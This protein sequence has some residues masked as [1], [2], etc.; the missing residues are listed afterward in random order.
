MHFFLDAVASQ[1]AFLGPISILVSL[2]FLDS[3]APSRILTPCLL[4]EHYWIY[5]VIPDQ[6]FCGENDMSFQHNRNWL[7]ISECRD[8]VEIRCAWESGVQDSTIYLLF[9]YWLHGETLCSK[10]KWMFLARAL[11]VQWSYTVSSLKQHFA[12]PRVNPMSHHLCS[13]CPNIFS[14][15]CFFFVYLIRTKMWCCFSVRFYIYS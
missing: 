6:Y 4:A 3:I 1:R 12:S 10:C 8:R 13:I 15:V 7:I 14:S 5:W 9:N 2:L 11:M